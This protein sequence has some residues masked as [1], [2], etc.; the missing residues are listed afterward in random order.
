MQYPEFKNHFVNEVYIPY[1]NGDKGASRMALANIYR[2]GTKTPRATM[3]QIN[4]SV[5]AL[6]DIYVKTINNLK[7]SGKNELAGNFSIQH[8]KFCNEVTNSKHP[9]VQ[10]ALGDFKKAMKEVY[11]SKRTRKLT[12]FIM[13]K[14]HFPI[15]GKLKFLTRFL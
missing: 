14:E 9:L 3:Y 1:M 4:S 12:E 5:H 8:I 10:D 7:A 15:L 6:K 13:G 11:P 2:N